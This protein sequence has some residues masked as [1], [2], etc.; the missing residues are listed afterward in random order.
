MVSGSSKITVRITATYRPG[1]Y[2]TNCNGTHTVL[3]REALLSFSGSCKKAP[4]CRCAAS[5]TGTFSGSAL[6]WNRSLHVRRAWR[7]LKGFYLSTPL[8]NF[9]FEQV[10]DDSNFQILSRASKFLRF[11]AGALS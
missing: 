2:R 9:K 7:T 11:S 5:G 10:A 6:Y 8:L 3:G 4:S 1:R